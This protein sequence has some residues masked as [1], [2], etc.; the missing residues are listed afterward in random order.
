MFLSLS[1]SDWLTTR[2]SKFDRA[3]TQPHIDSVHES[4]TAEG[5]KP[6]EVDFFADCDSFETAAPAVTTDSHNNILK[7]DVSMIG[8]F[9]VVGFFFNVILLGLF[10]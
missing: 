7:D 6:D 4:S 2:H 10:R 5:N 8:C 1:I 9:F 3:P